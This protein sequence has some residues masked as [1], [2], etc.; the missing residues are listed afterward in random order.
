MP[1][2]FSLAFSLT[3]FPHCFCSDST[4]GGGGKGRDVERDISEADDAIEE[5]VF[6]RERTIEDVTV[7]SPGAGIGIESISS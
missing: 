6:A 4:S 5:V 3:G 7:S 2:G 1:N